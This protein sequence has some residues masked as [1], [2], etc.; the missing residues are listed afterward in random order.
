M[1][2]GAGVIAAICG[3]VYIA[4]WEDRK[5]TGES[6]NNKQGKRSRRRVL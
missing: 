6:A 2:R 1:G 5:L 3:S 4:R